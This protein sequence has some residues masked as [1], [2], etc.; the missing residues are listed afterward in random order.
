MNVKAL[1]VNHV[2]KMGLGVIVFAVVLIW[3]KEYFGGSWKLERRNP[4]ALIAE[5]KQKRVEINSGKWPAEKRQEFALVDFSDRAATLLR[6][7]DVSKYELSTELFVPLNRPKEKAREPDLLA[8]ESLTATEGHVIL[9]LYP[10][11]EFEQE[12]GDMQMADAKAE[13]EEEV[14]DE[15]RRRDVAD[16]ADIMPADED[17]PEEFRKQRFKGTRKQ[18]LGAGAVRW[19]G[20]ALAGQGKAVRGDKGAGLGGGDDLRTTSG[21]R[22]QGRFF[23][24][25]RGVWPI[26]QQLERIQKAMHLPTTN[27]A[28]DHLQILDFELERQ[29]AAAGDDPWSKEWQKLD[30]KYAQQILDEVDG[31]D[32]EPLD[33]A[34]FDTVI[35]MP[36]PMRMF[37]VWKDHATHPRVKNYELS[38]EEQQRERAL[39]ARVKE[40]YEKDMAEFEKQRGPVPGGFASQSNDFR[41]MGNR[42][43]RN[44]PMAASEAFGDMA[45]DMRGA[46]PGGARGELTPADLTAKITAVGRLLLFRY[47]DFDVQPGYA[48]RY[49]VKLKLQN[50]NYQRDPAEV[51][52][53]SVAEGDSRMTPDS[54]ISNAAVMPVSPRYFLKDVE[55]NPLAD[56]GRRGR[57]VASVTIY[58]WH[59]K[60]GTQVYAT[61]P[62]D[63]LGQFLGGKVNTD[64]LDV[65]TPIIDKEDYN[66]TT[67][68]VLLDVAASTTLAPENHPDLVLP[69]KGKGAKT[70]SVG[71]AP[72]VLVVS[73]G[74][75]LKVISGGKSSEDEKSL[76][77]YAKRERDPF[78]DMVRQAD[79]EM[80]PLDFALTKGEMDPGRGKG[81][82]RGKG[83]K[84]GGPEDRPGM[85][86]DADPNPRRKGS[87]GGRDAM[88]AGAGGM[89]AGFG[90]G[91]IRGA[92]AGAM[93]P[94]AG[95][96]TGTGKGKAKGK[97]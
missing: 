70:V 74:G 26:R 20:D 47:F 92:G 90:P 25:V 68:D 2:E 63:S 35:T 45:R 80:N 46:Q 21:Q 27:A 39:Q 24:A 8:V 50:P 23:V 85:M 36:L 10:L 91:G 83:A 60:M 40:A 15:F 41:D 6:P 89:G 81:K 67:D 62:L 28:L 9:A 69:P 61:V 19:G 32:D 1:F 43:M 4:N 57:E 64:V 55:R 13:G 14:P 79:E 59:K 76:Q 51:V 75:D 12:E 54:N 52:D 42:M 95:T 84:G 31:F 72:E 22:P 73:G 33:M 87:R 71:I 34:V 82:G 93:P 37:G 78:K 66:F 48:Y 53:P 88:G 17:E 44:N 5:I 38:P 49:R 29:T 94:A 65:A 30:I 16:P 97:R 7:I 3:A 56:E 96:G 18:A 58:E 86:I 11:D 77:A